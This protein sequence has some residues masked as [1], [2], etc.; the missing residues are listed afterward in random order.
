MDHGRRKRPYGIR[1]PRRPLTRDIH[2]DLDLAETA[3]P[4]PLVRTQLKHQ[5]DLRGRYYN[6]KAQ[7]DAL[8]SLLRNLPDPTEAPPRAP[9]R[10]TPGT[11]KQLDVDDQVQELIADYQAG[12]SVRRLGERFG[13]ARQ[14]VSEILRRH[15][16]PVRQRGLSPEQVDEAVRLYAD[17]WSLARIGNQM[18]VNPQ[19]VLNRLR[20]RGVR[21]RDAQGRSR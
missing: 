19:T 16:V 13:I 5:V 6:P 2:T 20:E 15:E 14:T 4:T 18:D 9:A 17:G 11:A 3:S 21:T 8:E 1:T 10:R 7:V 12:V